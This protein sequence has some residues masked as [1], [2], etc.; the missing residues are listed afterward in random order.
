MGCQHCRG[1][2][3]C[4][5]CR[6]REEEIDDLVIGLWMALLALA[7]VIGAVAASAPASPR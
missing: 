5:A 2:V 6:E 4:D 3:K 1:L 7:L